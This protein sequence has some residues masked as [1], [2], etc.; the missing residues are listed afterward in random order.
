IQ[1]RLHSEVELLS[2]AGDWDCLRAAV[3]NGADAVYFGLDCGHNARARAK[4]FS[5]DDLKP[6]MEFVH[7]R[8]VRG[9]VTLNTLV[10]PS[11]LSDVEGLLDKIL[12]AHVDA[13]L[14]QDIGLAQLIRMHCPSLAIHAS[15]QMTLTS[16][17]SLAVVGQLGIQRVVLPRELSIDEI[18]Q[19]HEQASIE[20]EAFVHGALCVAYSGQC[21]TSESLGNRSANRGQCAQACRLPYEL[22][23]DGQ[24]VPTGDVRYLLSPQDLA[25]YDHVPQLIAAGVRSFKIEGRLK[26][27]EYV[28]SIT[29][30]YRQ[31]IDA[32]LAGHPA[33]ISFGE[34]QEMELTFS[35]GFSPGWLEGCDHKRL[36]PGL[37]SA[38]RGIHIGHVHEVRDRSV[39]IDLQGPLSAGDGIVFAG[40]RAAGTEVGGRVFQ[41]FQ[42]RKP[43]RQEVSHGR[44]EVT[45]TT[46]TKQLRTLYPGQ[47]VWKTDD[48][49][50]TRALR[51]TY[52]SPD[53]IRRVN[54]TLR[55]QAR[56]GDPLVIEG[57]A[58]N[59]G[60]CQFRSSEPLPL[61]TKHA[62]TADLF[63]T[64]LRRL[65]GTVYTLTHVD[66][67]ISGEPLVP[68][69][70]LGKAR[71][72]IVSQ[73]NASAVDRSADRNTQTSTLADL[74]Q[75]IRH[76]AWGEI[77]STDGPVALR[78]TVR[79]LGQ[80]RAALDHPLEGIYVD[81]QDIRQYR[82]AVATAHDR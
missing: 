42:R 35:R 33:S 43:V 10:F 3:E 9:Y 15:T 45:L 60:R 77:A 30:R 13:V 28:A 71:R 24:D 18:A 57:F 47:Q 20:L 37:S 19:I 52:S 68:L 32:T 6:N 16:A 76:R 44:V 27:P 48:P 61:A 23:C 17:E 38:K 40:D 72:S 63:Q 54:V 2:P 64:Q 69:S 51:K 36:V 39:T 67:E 8:G 56:T 80:L 14:V 46:D 41:L 81:F 55:I 34:K 66:A 26:A 65:G 78:V 12:A 21:L 58:D 1:H 22:I 29:R 73:L 25:A 74:Q 7:L 4:N 75:S 53:P 79:S 31:V 70:V 50:L 59:G 5:V 62:A 49:K 82:E 11:E